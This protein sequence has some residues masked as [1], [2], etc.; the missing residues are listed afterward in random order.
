MTAPPAKHTTASWSWTPWAHA[1]PPLDLRYRLQLIALEEALTKAADLTQEL[2]AER[3]FRAS[4]VGEWAGFASDLAG[5][6]DDI[7]A[8]RTEWSE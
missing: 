4:F 7:R 5:T 2:V 6:A 1:L 8:W 3:R